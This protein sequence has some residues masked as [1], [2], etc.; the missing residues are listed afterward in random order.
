M[1]RARRYVGFVA[2]GSY[3][4]IGF[5]TY[6][7]VL[8][9]AKWHWPPDFYFR[10]Y[11]AV[12]MSGFIGAISAEAR[13]AYGGLLLGWDRVFIV[14]FA[15]WLA[16]VGWRGGGFRYFVAGSAVVYGLV[17]LSENAAIYRFVNVY[18]LDPVSVQMASHLTMAKFAALY[19]CVLVLVAHLRRTV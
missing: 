2:L 16:L 19:L 7:T 4:M 14:S 5:I 12:M 6:A 1:Y 15:L 10:G 3:L 9:G 17:D 18:A 13:A 8:P 11:D